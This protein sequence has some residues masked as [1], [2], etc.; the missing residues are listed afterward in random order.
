MLSASVERNISDMQVECM[1]SMFDITQFR[2][3]YARDKRNAN[4]G[5]YFWHKSKV[6]VEIYIISCMLL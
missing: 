4:F 3:H 1:V 2:Q 5:H 6:F